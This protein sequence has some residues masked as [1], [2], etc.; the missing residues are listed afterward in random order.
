MLP[1]WA[2][3]WC[4]RVHHICLWA[5]ICFES[6]QLFF[7]HFRS[8]LFMRICHVSLSLSIAP[9]S[10]SWFPLAAVS[11]LFQHFISINNSNSKALF[12]F[13]VLIKSYS[14]SFFHFHDSIPILYFIQNT[15]LPKNI[16]WNAFSFFPVTF[17]SIL[18]H[19]VM[20]CIRDLNS[21]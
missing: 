15:I 7:P 3:H 1:C 19:F 20:I 10:A 6:R 17:V 2:V 8:Y 21:F 4:I 14:V 18:L 12:L 9:L 16:W 13:L 11:V 5:D